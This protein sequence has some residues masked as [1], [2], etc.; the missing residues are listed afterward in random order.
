MKQRVKNTM[1]T[2]YPGLAAIPRVC[3][4]NA[5]TPVTRLETLERVLQT[6]GLYLKRDNLTN[7]E[8]GGNK[9]RKLEYIIADAL[10]NNANGIL[11]F[12]GI[13][14]NHTIANSIFC[15]QYGLESHIFISPQ[16]N[17]EHCRTALKVNHHYGA[18]F[19]YASSLSK[20]FLNAVAFR[21]VHPKTY[22]TLPGAS[23]PLGT[24]GFVNAAF[25][26]KEQIKAGALPE[27]NHLH[28]AC[29]S[30]GTTAGLL[31]GCTL[32]G[33]RTKIHAVNVVSRTS[34]LK[35]YIILLARLALRLMR[36]FD[37]Q[38]P[39]VTHQALAEHLCLDGDFCGERYGMVTEEGKEAVALFAKEGV[40]LETTYTGKAA[41]AMLAAI[42]NNREE[43]SGD[44]HLFWNTHNSTS[45]ESLAKEINW[46]ELPKQLHKF[47]DGTVPLC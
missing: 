10:A 43:L 37:G 16:P 40:A 20:L 45:L 22:V 15:K 24:L 12:G 1:E 46:K 2:F 38:V 36:R 25:E 31:L 14:S 28:V 32:T 18:K 26:L 7:E 4:V 27:P 47:C 35:P 6:E 30:M 11:T 21:L 44:T 23:S 8:Y 19:H 17:T 5:P 13:G 42:G 33:M 29:G 3:L 41:A 34:K 9:C 39:D